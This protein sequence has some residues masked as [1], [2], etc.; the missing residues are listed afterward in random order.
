[1]KRRHLHEEKAAALKE[2]QLH[3]EMLRSAFVIAF[4]TF[5]DE[6]AVPFPGRLWRGKESLIKITCLVGN[7]L[8]IDTRKYEIIHTRPS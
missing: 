7:R 3:E 4:F 5:L 1:M 2:G 8:A 6:I